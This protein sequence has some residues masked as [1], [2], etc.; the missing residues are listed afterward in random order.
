MLTLRKP[1]PG[2]SPNYEIRGKYLGCRVEV[3][4]GTNRRPVA[5]KQLRKI[6][7]CIEEH[8][9][10]P[11]PQAK[12][13]K[14]Q[15]TFLSAAVAYMRDGGSRRYVAPLIKHFGETP[16][17][18]IDQ[19]A[20]DTAAIALHPGVT[21]ATRA[22]QAYTPISA[23]MHHA[24]GDKAPMVRRPKGAKG[25]VKKDFMWPQDCFAI[26]EE[27]D[28]IDREFGLY[29]RLLIYTGIR[30]SEGLNLLTA[31]MKPEERAAWLRTSKNEDP[32][33][34][35]LRLDLVGPLFAHLKTNP[36]ERFFRFKDGGWFKHLLT[37]A[38]LAA[39]GLPCPKRRPIGWKPPVYRLSFVGFHTFRHSWST[40]M[41]RY[42]GVD[43]QGLVATGN[44][45]DPKSAARY[46]H[47]VAREEWDRVDD[48]PAMGNGRGKAVGE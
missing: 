22:R 3:S 10:Y 11:A 9:C 13:D 45:R 28:K 23:I 39:C 46:A 37:R 8:G 2:K 40:W 21:P 30:K 36:G 24:L 1:R 33:M 7:E 48:L 16:L 47:V 14:G 38:K 19:D 29:L 4:A 12:P 41:R 6:E 32:R 31:D 34:L 35:R 26:I 15:P 43:L 27:A 25:R 44:W 20:I 18:E 5:Q 42:G 17:R